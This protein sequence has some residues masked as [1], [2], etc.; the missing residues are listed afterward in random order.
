LDT[1]LEHVDFIKTDIEGAEYGALLG[2]RKIPKKGC[3]LLMKFNTPSI[4]EY[5][6]EPNEVFN[7]ILNLGYDITFPDR[8]L[9]CNELN[10][11]GTKWEA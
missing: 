7:Y 1:I 5:G 11:L 10:E 8:P 4:R 3:V 9:T 2:M 6:E